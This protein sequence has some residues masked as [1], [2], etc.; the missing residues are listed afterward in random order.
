MSTG[1]A[2]TAALGA[3]TMF[4]FSAAAQHQ[5]ARSVEHSTKPSLLLTLARKPLWAASIAADT[6]AVVLQG[7][8]LREG[9]VVLVQTLL[10]AG[11]PLA[12]VLSAMLHRRALRRQEV[13]G[14]ALCSASLVLLAPVLSSTPSHHSPTRTSGLIAA[15]VIAVVALPLLALRH[16]DWYGGVLAGTAAGAVIGAGSV[17]LAVTAVRVGDWTALFH[18]VAPYAAAA[19]GVLGLLLAQI[20]FQTGDLGPPLAALSIV[21]PVVAVVLAVTSLHETL[22]TSGLRVAIALAGAALAVSGVLTLAAVSDQP[23]A[24]PLL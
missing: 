13:V 2:V 20:A 9:A 10:V 16:H 11:L 19:V 3:A 5:Q 6:V 15:V 12:A 21:E 24:S 14:L 22:P 23:S 7:L 17:L 4:G 8:A 18:S 1:L